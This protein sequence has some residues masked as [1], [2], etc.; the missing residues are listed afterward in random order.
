MAERS[1]RLGD[2]YPKY[3]QIDIANRRVLNVT[4]KSY[5]SDECRQFII[6]DYCQ[7][8]PGYKLGQ[9]MTEEDECGLIARAQAGD[10]EARNALIEHHTPFIIERVKHCI[11]PWASYH[12]YVGYGVEKFMVCI[13]KFDASKGFKLLTYAGIA[14]ERRIWQVWQRRGVIVVPARATADRS[15]KFEQNKH[16]AMTARSLEAPISARSTRTLKDLMSARTPAPDSRDE[17]QELELDKMRKALLEL[18]RTDPRAVDMIQMR[19]RGTTL[20]DAGAI[21]GLSRE[22]VRQIQDKAIDELRKLMGVA[23]AA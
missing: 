3:R 9:R 23:V 7:P 6:G 12:E 21:Y 15:E 14:I 22:R 10:I 2:M 19:F 4:A 20:T 13:S 16:R 8:I 5:R 18:G 17:G 11:P 1:T